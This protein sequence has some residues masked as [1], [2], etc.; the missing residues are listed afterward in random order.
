MKTKP[1]K[2]RPRNLLDFGFSNGQRDLAA[3]H[4]TP[5]EFA[6]AVYKAVP[7]FISM[8]EAH[9]AVDRYQLQW[10]AAKWDR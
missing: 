7:E 4:G 3:K 8:D 5:A 10:D 6:V 1:S 2:K 9:I